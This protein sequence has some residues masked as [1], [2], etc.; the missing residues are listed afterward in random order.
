VHG[1]RFTLSRFKWIAQKTKR[2]IALIALDAAI[3]PLG[4][5]S[6]SWLRNCSTDYKSD[7][8][9]N[10]ASLLLRDISAENWENQAKTAMDV[11]K[12]RSS[13]TFYAQ[14]I[15]SIT[16]S[17]QRKAISAP[18]ASV[19][20]NPEQSTEKNQT[21]SEASK[22][23]I[24]IQS[25]SADSPKDSA[26]TGIRLVFIQYGKNRQL[27]LDIQQALQKQGINAPGIE[28]VNGIRQEDIRY[29]NEADQQTAQ[30]LSKLIKAQ[31]GVSIEKIIDLSANHYKIASGQFEIWLR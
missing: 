1:R 9:I 12:R 14:E 22:A 13:E 8:V 21:I 23:A 27:A 10:V 2:D 4:Q 26:L 5:C 15:Q 17:L 18:D 30:A 24:S 29:A 25:L 16:G 7:Q 6:M 3:P 28:Q 31:N 19:L 20:N 11:I